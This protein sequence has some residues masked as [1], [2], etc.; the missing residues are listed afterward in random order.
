[1]MCSHSGLAL[2]DHIEHKDPT[3]CIPQ[4]PMNRALGVWWRPPHDSITNPRGVRE[5]LEDV[6]HV[7]GVL[8]IP[9][10]NIHWFSHFYHFRA[11]ELKGSA[12]L[13][14][15]IVCRKARAALEG[16]PFPPRKTPRMA[17][18]SV[19]FVF[20]TFRSCSFR[21]NAF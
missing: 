11:L 1:M 19:G 8:S 4:H 21:A 3:L 18:F 20:C 13:Y 12:T 14:R 16:L 17:K 2:L 9:Q 15:P 5:V 7:A 10:F 6:Q